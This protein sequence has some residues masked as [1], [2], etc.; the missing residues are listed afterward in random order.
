MHVLQ[1]TQLHGDGEQAED[2]QRR[3]HDA[4]DLSTEH[5]SPQVKGVV[6]VVREKERMRDGHVRQCLG[7]DS[8]DCS[9]ARR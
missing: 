6:P 2:V 8:N 1:R 3:Q 4:G 7:D 5:T 9:K